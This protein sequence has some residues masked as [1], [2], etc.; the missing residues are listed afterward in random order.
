MSEPDRTS[1]GRSFSIVSALTLVSR[2]TGLA[3]DAVTARIFGDTAI[4]SAFAAAFAIPNLFRRLFGEGALSAAFI[5]EYA[6]LVDSDPS[7]AR[8]YATLIVAALVV[9]TGAIMV[10]VMAALGLTLALG[11][12][13]EESALS[14]RL[15]IVMLPFMPLV[16][17]GATL[18]GMLQVHGRFGP[19]AAQPI[20]L[21]AF[22]LVAAGIAWGWLAWD[23]TRTA[24]AIGAAVSASGL[25]Q[26][27]WSIAALRPYMRWTA[28]FAGAHEAGRRTLR[29]FLPVVVGM[30]TIQI[31]TFLDMLIAM[32][33]IWI[34]P[35]VLG[36]A[37]PLDERSNAV[38]FYSQR[39]YQFP[40]GVFGIAVAT[41]VFPLLS[42]QAS[43]QDAFGRTLR[44]GVRLSLFIG[45]P[46]S[47]GLALVGHD[48]VRVMYGRAD[49]SMGFSA[50]GVARGAI[51]LLAYAPAVWAYSLNHVLTR[52]FYAAGDTVTPVR[53]SMAMVALNF[54]INVALIWVLR[55]AGLAAATSATAILQCVILARLLV[56]RG[57]AKPLDPG[58]WG[59]IRRTCIA[60]ALMCVVVVV[61][62][63][64][65]FGDSWSERLAALAVMTISGAG[66]FVTAAIALRM[67]EWRWILRPRSGSGA[68]SAGG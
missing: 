47:T 65:P 18:G 61:L 23:S 57:M 34:G 48:L 59:S 46:A 24:Y 66:T 15:I 68:S 32:W 62:R 58:V 4:G 44:T 35:T 13:G 29:R 50:D 30:G 36:I 28:S 27:A 8:R 14:V 12:P 55:E 39:L 49:G 2:V 56:R 16:C 6:R 40:L 64:V 7:I 51:V 45:I 43:E 1:I 25:V 22:I 60:T 37:Y 41:V 26:I 17:V 11:E 52:A 19:M 20:V 42:R 9:T 10:A 54:G 31:N 38:L 5:P 67:E 21:N 63:F 3:R 53:V 33:P